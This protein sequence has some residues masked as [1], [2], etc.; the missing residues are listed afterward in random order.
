MAG[1]IMLGVFGLI[2][3]L[4]AIVFWVLMLIDCL[5]NPRLVGTDKLVW[6]LVIIFLHVLGAALYFAIG[7]QQR[8]V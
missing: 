4:A 3:L 2:I 6:V 8:V 1:A 5:T 7:R